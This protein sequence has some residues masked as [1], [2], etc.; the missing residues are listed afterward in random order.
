MI[1]CIAGRPD[2][3]L[4]VV[5]RPVLP[6]FQREG[7]DSSEGSVAIPDAVTRAAQRTSSLL[8]LLNVQAAWDTP[9]KAT[10]VWL[11]EGL[12][13]VTKRAYDKMIK[14]EYLDLAELRPWT[15]Y[16]MVVG[17]ADSERLVVLPGLEVT[18]ARKKPIYSI[19]VWCQCFARYTAVM[20][21]K[22]Q[23]CAL[24]FMSHQLTVLKAHAEVDDPAWQMYDEAFR[25]K[26]ASVGV[27]E[28]K[29]M[30]VALYQEICGAGGRQRKQATQVDDGRGAR[31]VQK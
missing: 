4:S 3:A 27:R 1:L 24:G 29:G 2:A 8:A 14:W 12:G 13:S 25:E 16:D 7:G 19:L 30:D 15:A 21:S 20:A 17:D 31:V 26:M 22:F 10:R 18:Q 6:T 9:I 23:E 5:E 11:G 28:W